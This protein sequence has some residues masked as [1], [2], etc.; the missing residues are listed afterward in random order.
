VCVQN[1]DQIGN[2][3][4]GERITTLTDEGGVRAAH[5]VLALQPALPLYFQG[6]EWGAREPFQYFVSHSDAAL[7]EAV[8]KGRRDE[9]KAFSWAGEVPDPMAEETFRRSKVD[10]ARKDAAA[11]RWH[12]ALL[13]LRREHPAL[14]DDSRQGLRATV[15]GKV[16]LMRRGPLLVVASFD[17]GETD[18]ELPDGGWRPLLDSGSAEVQR[19][20]VRM[21]GR[22]AVVLEHE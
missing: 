10:R 1:H 13:K 11:L 6:E 7:A 17:P 8:R 5:A 9:F 19:D 22:G 3:A 20:G 21:R 12:K 2:R 16:L 14:Q 4:R 18:V 15:Q